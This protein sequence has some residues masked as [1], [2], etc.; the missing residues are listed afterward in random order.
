MTRCRSQK[1][2]L[3]EIVLSPEHDPFFASNMYQNFGDLGVSV[4]GTCPPNLSPAPCSSPLPR[5]ASLTTFPYSSI[6]GVGPLC[7]L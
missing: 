6:P 7:L 1:N 3:P 4:R 5:S 2:E